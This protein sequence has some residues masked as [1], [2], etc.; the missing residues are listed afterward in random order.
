MRA[1]SIS[2]SWRQGLVTLSGHPPATYVGKGKV[3]EIAGLV[4]SLDASVVVMDCP[5]SPV[6][7]RNLEKAWNCQGHRP[8]RADPGNLRPA[9]AHAR[10]RAAGRACASDLS[11]GPA[12]A[13]L[14]PSRAPARRLRLSRRPGRNADRSRPPRH[15]RAH[16]AHRGRAR[17]GQA[18]P[19]AAPRKPQ[20]RALSD[21]G[22]G[23]LHQ[24]RQVDAV[25]PHDA[26]HRPVG[27]HAVRHA[28][29]DL[30]RRRPAARQSR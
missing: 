3:D 17:Q 22:A 11:E 5:V 20:A 25:Q 2:P 4:K 15:R 30:A 13:L 14:D 19:Q 28:R 23:R 24:C 7:Q 9:R 18:H 16:R 12:G 26:S 8:H 10:R 21:R 27:R 1:P 29:P 6:Q